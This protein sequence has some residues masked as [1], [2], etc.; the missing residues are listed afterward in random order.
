MMLLLL[1]AALAQTTPGPMASFGDWAVACDNVRRCAMTSLQPEGDMDGNALALTVERDPGP[2]GQVVVIVA[3]HSDGSEA[4][5]LAI[6][7]TRLASGRGEQGEVRFAGADALRIARA[8]ANGARA[9]FG[10]R[11]A[12]VS[13][14]GSSAALRF[15][16]AE[17][18]R[19]GGVT[20]LV[21]RGPKPA[22]AVPAPAPLPLVRG[23]TPGGK[24]SPLPRAAL[25]RINRATGC[26]VEYDADRPQP[27]PETAALGGGATLVLIPCG[28]GAYNAL[29]AP[30]VLR[31]GKPVRA[32]LDFGDRNPDGGPAL[33][34]NARWDAERGLLRTYALGRGIG[35]CGTAADY[36]WD[37]TRFR[38]I[39]VRSM[40]ECR[41]SIEWLTIWRAA[42]RR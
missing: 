2:A 20:A 37:G 18:G 15:I 17:Q 41:G 10:N 9:T 13:L 33:L 8:L 39:H 35:D 40:G 31:G 26:G 5:D 38:A 4:G 19:A 36:A 42:L 34:V 22:A 25:D 11:G 1:P 14:T 6:D 30:Y 27:A 16:D 7:D 29:T 21:A 3:T 24:P 28:S 32:Q 12:G 23:I